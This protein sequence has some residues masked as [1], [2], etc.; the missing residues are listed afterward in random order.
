MKS[1]LITGSSGF[2]GQHLVKFLRNCNVNVIEC[3]GNNRVD[4]CCQDQVESLPSTDII[5]HLAARSFV[6]DSFANPLAFYK[7]NFISTLNILELARKNNSK[8]IFFSTYVYG[9]PIYL[10]ID[11][12]HPILPL[13]PYTRSKVICEELCYSYF[14]DFKLPITIF[15]PFNV[16]GPGQNKS[17][18]IP[19]II[20]Q[21]S[22]PTIQLQD[23]LP[24]R[25]FI[26]VDDILEAVNLAIQ[27]ES[28]DLQIFNLGSGASIS[29][30]EL[31][32]LIIQLANSSSEIVFSKDIRQGEIKETVADISRVKSLLGWN[33]KT[34]L[35]EGLLKTIQ[36]VQP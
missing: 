15:R 9:N 7:N 19:R 28:N 5:I 29:V 36:S 12:K 14:R 22:N 4:L 25:D 23:P 30:G 32:Q 27:Q 10:P 16:Y 31:A 24:K 13:N 2:I 35:E 33:P 3:G 6:P 18:L 1:V 17:F 34:A 26:Y 8:V 11:E 20:N 21:L